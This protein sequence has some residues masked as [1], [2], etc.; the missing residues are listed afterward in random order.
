MLQC[1]IDSAQLR[2][3]GNCLVALG[4]FWQLDARRII[5][6]FSIALVAQGISAIC[7]VVTT[8]LIP[9]V[10]GIEEFGYWQ[11]FI[12]YIGYVGVFHF[13]LSDGVYL[14]N[15]GISRS[16]IDKKDINSQFWMISAAQT[17]IAVMIAAVAIFGSFGADR[18]FV[19]LAT[20]AMIVVNNAALYWGYVCQAMNETRV[21]SFS[22][23]LES[24]LFL[25]PLS[26]LLVG[27]IQLFEPYITAYVLAKA[28]RL[29]YCLIKCR[30]FLSAGIEP[31]K[32]ILSS[33]RESIAVGIKLMIANTTGSLIVGAIRFLV[34]ANWGI[35][36]FS[37]V[38]FSLSLVSFFLLFISQASMVLFPSLR[39]AGIEEVSSFFQNA[40]S[41]LACIL[42]IA[43]VLY[44]PICWALGVW[45][46]EYSDSLSLFAL[47]LPLCVFDGRMDI[48]GTTY[49][50][51]L[52]KEGLLLK[53]NIGALAIS[54]SG[55]CLGAFVLHSVPFMLLVAVVAIAWRCI[56]T[57][58]LVSKELDLSGRSIDMGS[59]LLAVAATVFNWMI[60]GTVGFLLT[61]LAYGLFLVARRS[62]VSKLC[63]SI[64]RLKRNK[65]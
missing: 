39:Q 53:I 56:F 1:L 40:R 44:A 43:Y 34:D 35:E 30:D 19:L 26:L 6:D 14:I 13:G 20:A 23:A 16:E 25:V 54:L 27:G 11:L 46:P 9:K 3:P 52:R 47:I 63:F 50:K 58:W 31:L 60:G 36:I 10:L 59:I 65:W 42:P 49:L 8:L 61:I 62:D 28:C 17:G 55:A 38:S 48:I 37:S 15:G 4:E 41:V 51:V 64:A 24:V 45:L 33:C 7:S 2:E 57:E 5:T 21:F 12:F 18:T 32:D 29:A 22:V